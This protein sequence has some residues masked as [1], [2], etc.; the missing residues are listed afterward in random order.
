MVLP[1]RQFA[2]LPVSPAINPAAMYS[3]PFVSAN[4]FAALLS[5][6]IVAPN[7]EENPDDRTI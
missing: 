5:L 6:L 3:L 7:S 1:E 4:S 2:R